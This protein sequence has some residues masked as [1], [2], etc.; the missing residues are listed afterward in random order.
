MKV[1]LKAK[2]ANTIDEL[3]QQYMDIAMRNKN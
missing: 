3:K 2:P 1:D